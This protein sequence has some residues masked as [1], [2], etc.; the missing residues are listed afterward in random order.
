MFGII[1]GPE[2]VMVEFVNPTTVT[3]NN[4]SLPDELFTGGVEP[5]GN[6]IVAVIDED[7]AAVTVIG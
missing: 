6:V 5:W 4:P 3:G 1:L 2:N 7:V